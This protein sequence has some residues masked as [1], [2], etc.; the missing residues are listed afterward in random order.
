MNGCRQES[1]G[2]RRPSTTWR[3]SSHNRRSFE[4]RDMTNT[5]RGA[6]GTVVWAFL[7]V[8][9]SA[10]PDGRRI[11]TTRSSVHVHLDKSGAFSAF[12]HNHDV[13]A[14][15]DSG[16]VTET[17]S[18][19]VE[20]HLNSR[21]LRVLDPGTSAD[22]RGQIQKT[23]EG[24]QV[25]DVERYPEIHFRSMKIQSAGAD[26]WLVTGNL[27]LHGQTHPITADVTL[28][29]GLYRGSAV[30]KQSAFGITPVSF[31][32]GSVKVKDDL[33]IDFQIALSQ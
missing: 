22:T 7:I 5:L 17:G 9:T 16:E 24:P 31:A 33:K 25:L 15:I 32:G 27:E 29:D 13:E 12:G 14:P 8:T 21:K 26:H 3:D 30:L 11:D 18:P 20:I 10:S 6:L 1:G 23:M 28:K 2:G 19:L 4:V